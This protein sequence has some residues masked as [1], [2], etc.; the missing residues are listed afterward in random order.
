ME[1]TDVF[2]FH[3]PLA[4]PTSVNYRAWLA[5]SLDALYSLVGSSHRKSHA[6]KLEGNL[7]VVRVLR[8]FFPAPHLPL[9]PP[10]TTSS[11][12]HSPGQLRPIREKRA[13]TKLGE[14]LSEILAC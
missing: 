8:S 12:L 10:L 3:E 4:V 13:T 9:S 2:S 14:L 11:P 1:N 7:A 6:A 5:M